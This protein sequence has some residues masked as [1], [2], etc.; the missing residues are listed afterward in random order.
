MEPDPEARSEASDAFKMSFL[1]T[2]VLGHGRRVCSLYKRALRNLEA[3]YDRRYVT[4]R[5]RP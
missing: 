1:Q 2:E 3:W 5:S 4:Y